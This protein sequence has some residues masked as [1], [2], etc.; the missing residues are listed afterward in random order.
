MTKD[1]SLHG[2]T[3]EEAN[4]I[5]K[6]EEE[7]KEYLENTPKELL[8]VD[9]PAAKR[10]IGLIKELSRYTDSLDLCDADQ[11]TKDAIYERHDKGVP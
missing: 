5:T 3:E 10:L 7:F 2:F 6:R 8:S 4:I 1:Y 9:A 11:E